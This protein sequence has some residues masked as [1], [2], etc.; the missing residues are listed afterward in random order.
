MEF[1][2]YKEGKRTA[3]LAF[4]LHVQKQLMVQSASL[5][6]MYM[7]PTKCCPLRVNGTCPESTGV[8]TEIRLRR[9]LLFIDLSKLKPGLGN[10]VVTFC[11]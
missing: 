2:R 8:F 10:A 5:Q 4:L 3:N 11:Y 6:G 1:I 9:N 7:H